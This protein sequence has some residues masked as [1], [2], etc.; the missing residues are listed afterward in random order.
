[1]TYFLS[2]IG[3]RA[4]LRIVND[5]SIIVGCYFIALCSIDDCLSLPFT[6]FTFFTFH[7]YR[8][9]VGSKTALLLG[10]WRWALRV[11]PILGVIAVVLIYFINEPE[12]GEHEGS[13]TR[14]TSYKEDLI[15]K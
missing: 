4:V 7:S 12:R 6:F 15:G 9:I 8:Y 13:H 1:M 11:T 3:R 2:A 5:K 14:N 10:N